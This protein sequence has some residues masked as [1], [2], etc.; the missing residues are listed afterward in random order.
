MYLRKLT[1]DR[2]RQLTTRGRQVARRAALKIDFQKTYR[3]P[4][5]VITIDLA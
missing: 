3:P 5:K 2:G 1:S 4:K